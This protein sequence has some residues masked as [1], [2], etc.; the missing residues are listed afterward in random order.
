MVNETYYL[1][2]PVYPQHNVSQVEC[3]IIFYNL[4]LKVIKLLINNYFDRLHKIEFGPI[5]LLEM[6]M[7]TWLCTYSSSSPYSVSWNKT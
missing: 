4:Y 2:H 3:I 7:G 6:R 5:P 1:T